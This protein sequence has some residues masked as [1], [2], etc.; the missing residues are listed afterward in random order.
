MARIREFWVVLPVVVALL[1]MMRGGHL[2]AHA[3][4]PK[5][6]GWAPVVARWHDLDVVRYMVEERWGRCM[7]PAG[8]LSSQPWEGL[9]VHRQM[10]QVEAMNCFESVNYLTT[11]DTGCCMYREWASEEL[12]NPEDEGAWMKL[13]KTLRAGDVVE[14]EVHVRG[15]SAMSTLF[16]AQVCSGEGALMVGANNEARFEIIQGVPTETQ[17]WGVCTPHEYYYALRGMDDAW[18]ALGNQQT[19]RVMVYRAPWWGSD[20]AAG[21]GAKGMMRRLARLEGG[22]DPPILSGS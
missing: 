9:D 2:P 7:P 19:Y 17:R 8:T 21:E 11:G 16:H 10:Q 22:G 13:E 15:K 1:V 12:A 5:M 4:G 18:R 6:T 20:L 3:S 14:Y